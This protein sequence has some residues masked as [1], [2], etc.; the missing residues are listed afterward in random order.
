[1]YKIAYEQ[2]CGCE[3]YWNTNQDFRKVTIERKSSGEAASHNPAPHDRSCRDG[4]PA[5]RVHLPSANHAHFCSKGGVVVFVM[6][7]GE[8]MLTMQHNLPCCGRL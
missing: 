8:D 6:L 5:S 2:L 4:P 1:M 7:I 3:I